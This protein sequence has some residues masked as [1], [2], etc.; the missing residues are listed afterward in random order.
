MLSQLK[1]NE[2][3]YQSSELND[4]LNKSQVK[5]NRVLQKRKS[6]LSRGPQNQ[7]TLIN[8]QIRADQKQRSFGSSNIPLLTKKTDF[9][10]SASNTKRL[11]TSKDA[12]SSSRIK[13]SETGTCKRKE[14]STGE[15]RT[16]SACKRAT[17]PY[18]VMNRV[19][20]QNKTLHDSD[21]IESVYG[22]GEKSIK[23]NQKKERGLISKE[24]LNSLL[25]SDHTEW[26]D[27]IRSKDPRG[28]QKN[29]NLYQSVNV[30]SGKLGDHP[31]IDMQRQMGQ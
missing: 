17:T 29:N 20:R 9:K 23:D 24:Y 27:F 8:L 3:P 18:E 31:T 25:T 26:I 10:Y 22:Q 7:D 21:T 2:A 5:E 15:L 12:W 14:D 1:I 11:D 6:S 28:S 16:S 30:Q 19:F 13:K 4:K